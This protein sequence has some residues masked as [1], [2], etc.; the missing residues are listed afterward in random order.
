[1]E[2]A[3]EV[4]ILLHWQHRQSV[5][6]N[7]TTANDQSLSTL[8]SELLATHVAM[9]EETKVEDDLEEDN[10]QLSAHALAALQEFYAE[11]QELASSKKP[12]ITED[13]VSSWLLRESNIQ[14]TIQRPFLLSRDQ[15]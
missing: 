13:W 4:D 2:A 8:T 6:V 3:D 10:P 5:G 12:V 9:E 7:F 11:Q 14:D 15:L 1:M